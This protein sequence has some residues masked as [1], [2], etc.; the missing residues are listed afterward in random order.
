LL[1]APAHDPHLQKLTELAN[2]GVLHLPRAGQR[3]DREG[4]GEDAGSAGYFGG[5]FMRRPGRKR[6][7][8]IEPR[9]MVS[10]AMELQTTKEILAVVFHARS[11]EVGEMIR[12]SYNCLVAAK[13][14]KIGVKG[15]VRIHLEIE[16][17]DSYLIS[18]LEII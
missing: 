14:A 18:S 4:R 16:C 17:S 10:R 2:P 3:P 8:P 7:K 9:P 1:Y 11:G 15:S 12:I 5:I 6:A 13:D